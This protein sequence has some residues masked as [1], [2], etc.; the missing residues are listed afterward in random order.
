MFEGF[1]IISIVGGLILA[2]DDAFDKSEGV[3]KTGDDFCFIET[4]KDKYKLIK[5]ENK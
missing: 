5:C 4:E 2:S 3:I 1:V